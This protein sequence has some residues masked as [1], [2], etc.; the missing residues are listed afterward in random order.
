[1]QGPHQGRH[2]GRGRRRKRRRV[3]QFLQPC[4]LLLLQKD[5]A[6]GY[7]LLTELGRFGFDSQR[8]DPTLIYRT[9]HEMEMAGWVQSRWD[10]DE[11]LG[12]RRR[13]YSLLD[14]GKRQLKLWVEDLRRTQSE[15]ERLLGEYED[16][17]DPEVV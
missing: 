7:A 14:E 3:L 6:H 8:I 15:I 9:L 11:S 12:P 13:V 2:E 10:E 4:L 16:S 17:I 5:A 1:M